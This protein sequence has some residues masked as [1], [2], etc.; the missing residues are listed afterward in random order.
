MQNLT[1]A[2]DLLLDALNGQTHVILSQDA[3]RRDIAF[4]RFPENGEGRFRPFLDSDH[5]PED[6]EV[7]LF[8]ST[9]LWASTGACR[10]R[11]TLRKPTVAVPTVCHRNPTVAPPV[12]NSG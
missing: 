5:L 10:Y 6:L 4:L 2:H 1:P 3:V 11:V 9:R 7:C 8:N 12:D